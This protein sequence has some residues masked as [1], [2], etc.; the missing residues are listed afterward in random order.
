MKVDERSLLHYIKNTQNLIRA[1]DVYCSF[2]RRVAD[3]SSSVI[4]QWKS[5][6]DLFV[7]PNF[8]NFSQQTV[9]EKEG[10]FYFLEYL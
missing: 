10:C 4:I 5:L 8:L 1:N 2:E 3:Q 7:F 6:F 9:K